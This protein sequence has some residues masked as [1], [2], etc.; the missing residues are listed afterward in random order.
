MDSFENNGTFHINKKIMIWKFLLN[1]GPKAVTVHE[2]T[3][4]QG[5]VKFRNKSKMRKSFAHCKQINV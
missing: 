5:L 3:T 2:L 4:F 1:L